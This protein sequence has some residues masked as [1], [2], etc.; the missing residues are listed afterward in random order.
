LLDVWLV[1]AGSE[2]KGRRLG[3]HAFVLRER[4]R[5]ALCAIRVGALADELGLL[6]P[7]A[8]GSLGDAFVDIPE[9]RLVQGVS[10]VLAHRSSPI[11]H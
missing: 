11:R 6:G 3:A 8:V 2:E 9:E 7:E 4:R 5:H 10:F 1:V